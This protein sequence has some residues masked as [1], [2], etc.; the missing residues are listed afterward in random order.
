MA[1][2]VRSKR[3]KRPAS[4]LSDS[5]LLESLERRQLLASPLVITK[6]G[7]YS[8]TWESTDRKTPA[9]LID[10]S[11][12]V[13][14]QNSTVRGP[15]DLIASGVDHVHLTVLNSSGYGVNPNVY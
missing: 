13:T 12:P 9:V 5:R 11:D 8:G 1:R 2:K 7:T 15:G 3:R 6:G 10:T 14:I 4:P